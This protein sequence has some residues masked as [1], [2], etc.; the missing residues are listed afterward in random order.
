MFIKVIFPMTGQ[1]WD[2]PRAIS[3]YWVE[4]KQESQSRG[5]Q[6]QAEELNDYCD[7]FY[8]I[9]H[10]ILQSEISKNIPRAYAFSMNI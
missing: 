10:F 7:F 4:R 6:W 9:D 1:A 5:K 8:I 3:S 2:G